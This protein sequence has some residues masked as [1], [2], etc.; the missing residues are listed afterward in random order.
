MK[1]CKKATLQYMSHIYIYM[2]VPQHMLE[3]NGRWYIKTHNIAVMMKWKRKCTDHIVIMIYIYSLADLKYLLTHI[4][5]QVNNWIMWYAFNIFKLKKKKKKIHSR[6]KNILFDIFFCFRFTFL[7]T[8]LN[9]QFSWQKKKNKLFPHC[10]SAVSTARGKSSQPQAHMLSSNKQKLRLFVSQWSLRRDWCRIAQIM[11]R[12]A[13][14]LI[15]DR[16][17]D[18]GKAISVIKYN[19]QRRKGRPIRKTSKIFKTLRNKC[20]TNAKKALQK[21]K[22]C[23]QL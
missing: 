12:L 19:R 5:L 4:E 7:F 1:L 13:R 14:R 21:T 22:R 6:K 23:L 2:C 11:S 15:K 3:Y 16:L 8:P 17:C 18:I 20:V 10:I 9:I